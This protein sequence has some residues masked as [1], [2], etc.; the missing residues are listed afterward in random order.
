M[1]RERGGL[2]LL[3]AVGLEVHMRHGAD[4]DA[5]DAVRR[6]R[7]APGLQLARRTGIVQ[8]GR[9]LVVA[10]ADHEG[11]V[12]AFLQVVQFLGEFG[13]LVE[14]ADFVGAQG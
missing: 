4:R 13:E 9:G 10:G 2:V 8:Q 7:D 12:V 11:N 14:R 1:P 6:R 3:R 5:Q